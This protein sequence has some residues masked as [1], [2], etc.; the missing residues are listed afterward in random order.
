MIEKDKESAKRKFLA[1]RTDGRVKYQGIFS[2][3]ETRLSSGFLS[4]GACGKSFI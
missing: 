2:K 1:I 3:K 4:K